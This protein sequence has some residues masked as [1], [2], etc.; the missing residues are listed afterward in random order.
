MFLFDLQHINQSVSL[1]K[2]VDS[3]GILIANSMFQ[4]K[5]DQNESSARAIHSMNSTLKMTQSVFEGNAGDNGGVIKAENS[6]LNLTDNLFVR[7]LAK[8]HGG[9][10]YAS[11]S[12]VVIEGTLFLQNFAM[13]EG[14][15]LYCSACIINMTS[16]HE[17]GL[18]YSL[19]FAT[20][21][22]ALFLRNSTATLSGENTIE[23]QFNT[24]KASKGAAIHFRSSRFPKTLT[25]VGSSHFA[26][27]TV[28]GPNTAGGAVHVHF[29]HFFLTCTAKFLNNK[30][31]YCG[32][33]LYV[34]GSNMLIDGVLILTENSAEFGGA[35]YVESSRVRLIAD[36]G[37]LNFFNNIAWNQGGGLH[38]SNLVENNDVVISTNFVNNTAM[39][40]GGALYIENTGRNVVYL[41]GITI[42]DSVAS[43]L[44]VSD[45]SIAF[46]GDTTITHNQGQRG[47]GI[48]SRS[49]PLLFTGHTLFSNN[50]G[51]IGGAIFSL[52][53][54][55]LTFNGTARFTHNTAETDGG[56]IYAIGTNINFMFNTMASFGFNLAQNGGAVYLRSTS[57]LKT[58]LHVHFTTFYNHA[59][60]YGGAI[61]YKDTVIPTQCE[62]EMS[63]HENEKLELPYCFLKL[64]GIVS[65][66]NKY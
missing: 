32:G 42:E 55:T 47:G 39:K 59:S 64:E 27:N 52:F 5:G 48:Y 57:I 37:Q 29:S 44:C 35:M 51:F 1:L 63:A 49:S 43:A 61:Y 3:I 62:F 12:L 11:Q 56:A 23:F 7:N 24:A 30:A 31:S 26:N 60:G 34:A 25:M 66:P 50:S 45:G 53:E 10:I 21:G 16:F 2:V 9:A 40:C 54:T 8:R 20:R 41:M 28:S 46:V 13:L 38:I 15:A 33:G 14:G 22:A 19:N 4:G 17:F 65:T 36:S 58:E 6:A 18:L